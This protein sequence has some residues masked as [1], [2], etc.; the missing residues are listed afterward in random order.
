MEQLRSVQ[1]KTFINDSNQWQ[2]TQPI[3]GKFH[4]WGEFSEM[5]SSGIS[6]WTVAIVETSNGEIYRVPPESLQ[7]LD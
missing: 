7:F 1:F 2:N 6:R 3:S 4:C 5:D